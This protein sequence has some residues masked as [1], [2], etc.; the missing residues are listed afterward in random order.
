MIKQEE[1][2]MQGW[3]EA[4]PRYCYEIE[5]KTVKTQ[6]M[7]QQWQLEDLHISILTI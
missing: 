5:I 7:N 4:P 2:T 6:E 3:K 1:M